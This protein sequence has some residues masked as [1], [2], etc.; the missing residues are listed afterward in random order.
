ME[1]ELTQIW[2]D[3]VENNEESTTSPNQQSVPQEY[4]CSCGKADSR[5]DY[6]CT[7]CGDLF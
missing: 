6:E 1:K 7:N 4:S 3:V 2:D 5:F